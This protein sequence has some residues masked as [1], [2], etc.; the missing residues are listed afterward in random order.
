MR[1]ASFCRL[2]FASVI[3]NGDGLRKFLSTPTPAGLR[4]Q[5]T[6]APPT[7]M[8]PCCRHDTG[9]LD[10]AKRGKLDD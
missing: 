4:R 9:S 8:G 6:A 5:S 10:I 3:L 1:I 2:C 7:P